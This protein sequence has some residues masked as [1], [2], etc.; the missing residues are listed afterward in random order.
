MAGIVG[1]DGT[2]SGG[3]YKGIA[4]GATILSVGVSDATGMAYESDVVD[5]LQW[6]FENKDTYNIQVVNMSLNSTVEDSYNS[7]GI[8]AAAEILW[9]SGVVVVVAAG[10]TGVNGAYN[11][12]R[13]APAN[14]P[15]LIVVGASDEYDT[16]SRSDDVVASFTAYGYSLDNHLRPDNVPLLRL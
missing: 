5:G 12:A 11:T 4:P 2:A 3:V 9:F 6:V 13:S 14:D 1:G 10:N 7:S 15:F 8:D 16:Q